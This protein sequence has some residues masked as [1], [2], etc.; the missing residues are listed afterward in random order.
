MFRAGGHV[1][2]LHALD[3]GHTLRGGQDRILAHVF[4]IASAQRTAFDVDGRAENHVLASASGFL[5]Q[6]FTGHAGQVGVPC[7]GDRRAG[8]QVGH[9][10]TGVVQRRPIV[11][12]QFGAHAHR[13]IIHPE[14]RNASR[15]ALPLRNRP[16]ACTMAIFSSSV[17]C[18]V[19]SLALVLLASVITVMRFSFVSLR[20]DGVEIHHRTRSSRKHG[21][22]WTW[23]KRKSS[24]RQEGDDD[25]RRNMRNRKSCGASARFEESDAPCWLCD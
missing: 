13:T 20:F 14:R 23:K 11:V 17:S 3:V 7:G 18:A 16:A 15:S 24:D 12:M 8:R 25:V 22:K 19:S 2:F 4:E 6:Y 10:V 5:P 21:G 9:I 1:G